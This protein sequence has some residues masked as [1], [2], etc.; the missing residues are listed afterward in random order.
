[1][2][3]PTILTFK[4]LSFWRVG[5]GGAEAAGFDAVCARDENGLPKIPGKQVRGLFREA[6]RTSGEILGQPDLEEALFGSRAQPGETPPEESRAGCLRFSD[7][8]LPETDRIALLQ[9]PELI[10]TL[11]RSKRTTAILRDRM[12][13]KPHSL[14]LEEVVIPL[15]LQAVVMPLGT[16]TADWETLLR[17][18]APLI[19]AVGAGRTRGLGRAIVTV[20]EDGAGEDGK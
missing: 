6:I 10:K 20:G 14:R 17:D 19:R 8:S 1:M 7:A 12:V 16:P 2:T 13:A 15:D 11:F 18:A 3:S 4:L 9:Q 5:T